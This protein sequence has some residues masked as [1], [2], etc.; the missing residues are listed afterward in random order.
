MRRKVVFIYLFI[1]ISSLNINAQSVSVKGVIHADTVQVNTPFSLSFYFFNSGQDTLF[2]D[3]I[4]ANIGFSLLGMTQPPIQISYLLNIPQSIFAPGDSILFL[5]PQIQ[6]SFL[7]AGDH[8]V[9]IWPS[10]IVPIIADTSITNLHAI[11]T[12]SNINEN[13]TQ[14]I[15]KFKA[16]IYDLSGRKYDNINCVPSGIIYIRDSKKYI[17]IKE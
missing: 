5:D 9:T 8:I 1:F 2:M 10:S 4:T 15:G 13:L 17:K 6:I 12:I 7:T 14:N 3:S 16:D 11:S